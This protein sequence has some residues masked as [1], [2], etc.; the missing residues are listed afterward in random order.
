M[1]ER[2]EQRTCKKE[3][4]NRRKIKGNTGVIRWSPGGRHS[5][6]L[7]RMRFRAAASRR[8]GAMALST[9]R[10]AKIAPEHEVLPRNTD[11]KTHAL[12]E[13]RI[14]SN[15]RVTLKA[16]QTT[17]SFL[18]IRACKMGAHITHRHRLMLALGL[19]ALFTAIPIRAIRAC[20]ATVHKA[21]DEEARLES[22][23]EIMFDAPRRQ[24]IAIVGPRIENEASMKV[25]RASRRSSFHLG[26]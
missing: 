26:I 24:A 22:Q 4:K 15:D 11:T 3:N 2:R 14:G 19:G 6:L 7:V 12:A 25:R 10:V 9:R 18:M 13:R 23:R 8:D 21:S 5:T 20:R 16:A 1:Q 17:N